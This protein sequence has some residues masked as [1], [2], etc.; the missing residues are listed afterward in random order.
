MIT[1]NLFIEKGELVKINE[2]RIKGN[3]TT[4]DFVIVRECG[5]NL[6][7]FYNQKLIDRIGNKLQHLDI[8]KNVSEPFLSFHPNGGVLNLNVVEANN[9]FFDGIVGYQPSGATNEKGYFT[10]MIDIALKNLF[11]TGRKF[12]IYWLKESIN[13]QQI[14][15]NYFEPWIFSLP[16]NISLNFKERRQDSTFVKRD[17]ECSSEFSLFDQS[18]IKVSLD[19][20]NVIPGSEKFINSS[21]NNNRSYSIGEELILDTRDDLNFPENGLFISNKIQIGNKSYLSGNA[22]K[23]NK[24]VRKYFLTFEWYNSLFNNQTFYFSLNGELLNTQKIE[25]SDMFF[26][27]GMRSIRGYKENQFFGTKIIWS[28][29]EYRLKLEKGSYIYPLLDLGYFYRPNTIDGFLESST[30]LCGYGIGINL[31]TAIGIIKVNFAL[32]KDDTFS[33]GKIHFGFMNRF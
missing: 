15:L 5:I 3:E 4:K 9:N 12:K 14:N 32:G 8:F 25:Y 29:I 26:L 28:N 23:A 17:L 11:G 18:V 19:Y 2:I 31:D 22:D 6:G 16:I 7:D 24:S 33:Q 30:F 27:G 20:E 1:I 10:G 13:N 21:F